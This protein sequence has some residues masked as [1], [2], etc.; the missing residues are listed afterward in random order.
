M[1]LLSDWVVST[2]LHTWTILVL[3]AT[4][5]SVRSSLLYRGRLTL[6]PSYR[7]TC[8]NR[9]SLMIMLSKGISRFHVKGGITVL[10]VVY[11]HIF[12]IKLMLNDFCYDY[13]FNLAVI[14]V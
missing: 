7:D 4:V 12:L 6:Q 5:Q 1:I 9:L 2:Q 13:S 8:T 14:N 11:V 3:L 10:E